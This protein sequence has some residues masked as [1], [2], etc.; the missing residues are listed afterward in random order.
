MRLMS[1]KVDFAFKELMNNEKVRKGFI[2]A[3]LKIP[4]E[5]IKLTTILNTYLRQEHEANKLGILD[6]RVELNDNIEI[7]IEMQVA[8]FEYWAER[9]LFYTSKM[10]VETIGVGEKYNILK[11]VVHISILDFNLLKG[12][13]FYN[14]F[15]IMNS[16]THELYTDK[17]EFHI[18]ELPKIPNNISTTDNLLTLWS[19]F[20]NVSGEN[21]EVVKMIATKNE[22]ITEAY[23]ELQKIS[24]DKEKRLEYEYRQK[25]LYDYN[26]QK[27]SYIN[28]GKI[29]GKSEVV[30][31]ML[32][33]GL[34]L[35]EIALFTGLTIDEINQVKLSS[36]IKTL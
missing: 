23:N 4:V 10:Y 18:I 3:V 19:E 1:L 32:K 22:Y 12:D 2:S 28:K 17:M 7:D 29:E 27:E 9:T 6:V 24:A 26:T 20:I 30:E 34:K 31:N 21:E 35:D 15:R 16:E 13:S 36:K 25:A 5:Q 14:C 8:P 33:L 11:K